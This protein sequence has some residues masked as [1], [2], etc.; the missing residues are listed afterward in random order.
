MVSASHRFLSRVRRSLMRFEDERTEDESRFT[1]T[2]TVEPDPLDGGFVA[3]VVD[4]PGCMS[5]GETVDEALNNVMEALREI[6]AA[7]LAEQKD[8]STARPTLT[9]PGTYKV[10]V[11]C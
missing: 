10:P 6:M 7:S 8:S 9:E 1:L 2:V 3:S 4:L 5:E 11:G